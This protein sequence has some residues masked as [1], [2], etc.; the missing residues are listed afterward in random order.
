MADLDPGADM[1]PKPGFTAEAFSLYGV[2]VV[3][4]IARL[5]GKIRRVGFKHLE[6][7]DGFIAWGLIWYT[8]LCVSLHEIDTG[9]G[10]NFMTAKE[11]ATLTP[12]TTAQ[13]VRGSKWVYVSEHA[14]LMTIWSMKAAMLV[15]YAR[16]TD[17]LRQRRLLMALV[18]W[19]CC[20]FLGDELSLFLMCRPISQLWAVPTR[21]PAQ[22]AAYRDYQI[23]NAVFNISTDILILV[24]GLPP[25]LK[26]RLSIQQ[27]VLLTFLFGIG[28]FVIAAA[29]ARAVYCLVPSLISYV[30]MYWY[31]REASVAVYVTTLPGL[32]VFL[33]EFFPFLGR[34]TSCSGSKHTESHSIK[35]PTPS[36]RRPSKYR[37]PLDAKSFDFT[38]DMWPTS[39]TTI[40]GPHRESA[41]LSGGQSRGHGHGYGQMSEARSMKLLSD[42]HVDHDIR[43]EASFRVENMPDVE[44][45]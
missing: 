41:I 7:D 15:L 21:D 36:R 25:V 6:I 19:V 42:D 27:K 2:G 3:F 5:A 34:F 8:I 30:Y 4:I 32:W 43:Q 28:V 23:V 11:E 16:I 10:S 9:I 26:A 1:A 17:G 24:F 39:G 20:A 35:D 37:H 14:M 38:L 31:F 44:K 22:C 12:E 40:S 18:V 45:G 33:R 13:R 29:T